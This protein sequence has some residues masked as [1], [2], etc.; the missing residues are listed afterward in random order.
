M[1]F[2]I[3][4][5]DIG[6][7]Q[8]AH[9]M[10]W[11]DGVTTNPS[12]V[13]KTGRKFYDVLKDICGVVKGPVS[14][15]VVGLD[16]DTMV[17]EGREL[18]KSYD[19][20]AVK[21]P[22]S[23]QGLLAVR[24]LTSEGIKTNVTLIFSPLQALLAAKAGAKIISP[25]AGRVDDYLRTLNNITFDKKHFASPDCNRDGIKPNGQQV[26]LVGIVAQIKSKGYILE[27]EY[28]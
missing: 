1:K 6:E 24:R 15:E 9:A 25:F 8:Q 2:F 7:I 28:I 17:K 12:L 18:A 26:S 5:A 4:T 3:D 20:I 19:N 10:G 11:V 27:L 22:M 16:A 21:I 14:A 13:A 23:E